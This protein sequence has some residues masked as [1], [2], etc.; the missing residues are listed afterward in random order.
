MSACCIGDGAGGFTAAA[1]VGVGTSPSRVALGDLDGDG[2]LDAVVANDGSDNVSVLIGDGAGGFTAA[3]PV[4]AGGE[5]RS[6]ALGDVD[7]DGDLDA[8]VANAGS[9]NVSVLHRRRRGRLHRRRAG[10]R[11]QQPQLP[12]RSATWTA[13]ATS[14][15]WSRTSAATMSAC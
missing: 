11:R 13:T 4:G 5:P 7:G 2:D 6:V 12:S 14:T 9:N 3:A 10:R 8:L 15:P 1:P